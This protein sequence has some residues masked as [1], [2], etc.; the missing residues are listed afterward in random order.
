MNYIFNAM[1]FGTQS[2]SSSLIL[3]IADL[4]SKLKTWAD[5]VSRLQCAPT[6]MKFGTDSKSNMLIMNTVLGTDD[7]NPKL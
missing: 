4:D 7:L 1:K 6:F 5:L 3:N 2:R